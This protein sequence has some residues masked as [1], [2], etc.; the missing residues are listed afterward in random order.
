MLYQQLKQTLW[1]ENRAK[2]LVLLLMILLITGIQLLLAYWTEPK[3][4][5]TLALLKQARIE[6]QQEDQ[7]LAA[8]GG[9]EVTGLAEDLEKFYQQI[10]D[11]TGLGKFIGRLYSYAESAEIDIA[12]ITYVAKPVIGTDLLG[13][14]LTFSV[15]G[16][17]QQIKKFIH[18]LETSPSLLILDRLALGEERK[19][20]Q[21]VVRLQMQLQTFF[22]GGEQ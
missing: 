18:Q 11:Q 3:L 1:G 9:A 13:Y 15:S 5:T 20:K 4:D 21:E 14:Q 10:P 8:G 16:S 22:R 12:Q 2:M 17:Y 7:R 6:K 19:D